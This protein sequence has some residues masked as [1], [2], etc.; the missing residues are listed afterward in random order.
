M[1][2]FRIDGLDL[3]CVIYCIPSSV[4]YISNTTVS[5]AYFM[6]PHSLYVLF[7]TFLKQAPM[8]L[9]LS[10]DFYFWVYFDFQVIKFFLLIRKTHGEFFHFSFFQNTCLRKSLE[11]W[12]VNNRWCNYYLE[13]FFLYF[14]TKSND[15]KTA[16]R[17]ICRL[18]IITH[19]G[20]HAN[21]C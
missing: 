1:E 4:K 9:H 12:N 11:I 5:H 18:L 20:Y 6:M 10:A 17:T 19:Y 8:L 7:S 16:V 2:L 21:C 3:N 14:K 15:D 13:I